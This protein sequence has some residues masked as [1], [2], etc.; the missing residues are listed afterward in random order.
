MA[1]DGIPGRSRVLARHS[2]RLTALLQE[3]GLID[4]QHAARLVSEIL[5]DVV[6]QI[7]PHPV[8]VPGGGVQQ[9]LRTLRPPLADRLG[10]LP[11]ILTLHS[12]EQ[13]G[14]I[15]SG[16]LAHLGT[17]EVIGDAPV[18]L[19]QDVRAPGDGARS[20]THRF[21]DHALLLSYRGEA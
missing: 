16:P 17:R 8:G 1:V 15:P 3:A 6:A 5:D 13:G 20:A 2:A 11:A 10:Q 4:D 12:V 9:A 18:Q 21:R 19:I 14:E 7:V